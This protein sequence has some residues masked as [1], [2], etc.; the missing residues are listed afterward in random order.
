MR[1]DTSST[2]STTAVTDWQMSFRRAAARWRHLLLHWRHQRVKNDRQRKVY[3]GRPHRWIF[4]IY[5]STN[6]LYKYLEQRWSCCSHRVTATDHSFHLII[7]EQCCEDHGVNS[8]QCSKDIK[9]I[10]TRGLH[11]DRNYTHLQPSQQILYPSPPVPAKF[12]SIPIPS[13]LV[14]QL[15]EYGFSCNKNILLI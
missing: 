8:K 7:Y 6:R 4:Y 11:W 5:T 15:T 2:T 14:Q 9:K 10:Q 3:I 1:P 13:P 12:V